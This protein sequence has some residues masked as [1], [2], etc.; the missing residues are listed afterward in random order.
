[1]NL[2]LAVLLS[3]PANLPEPAYLLVDTVAVRQECLLTW[4]AAKRFGCDRI[5]ANRFEVT[6]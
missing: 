3:L 1:M 2:L 4:Y 6:K 5:F